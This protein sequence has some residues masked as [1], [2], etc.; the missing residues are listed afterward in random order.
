MNFR[1][2]SASLSALFMDNSEMDGFYLVSVR[3]REG[4]DA[5]A[6]LV[7]VMCLCDWRG[8]RSPS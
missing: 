6:G 5:E 4:C 2:G 7:A 8:I 1:V 3:W